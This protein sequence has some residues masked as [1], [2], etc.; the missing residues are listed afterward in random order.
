MA[1]ELRLWEFGADD[2]KIDSWLTAASLAHKI[3]KK[4]EE[5]FHWKF[6]GSP[7]GRAIL[8]CAFDG[9]NVA[10]CVSMGKGEMTYGHEIFPY[11]LVYDTFVHPAYQGKG[12][13]KKL[14]VLLEEECRNQGSKLS[15]IFPNNN[16]IRGWKHSGYTQVQLTEYKIRIIH[17]VKVM[18]YYRDLRKSFAC[19]PANLEDV[20]DNIPMNLSH[21][22]IDGVFTPQWSAEYI[23]WRFLTFPVGHYWIFN[24][25]DVFAIFRTGY[26]G[27]LKQAE[28]LHI[29]VSKGAILKKQW[30]QVVRRLIR[31]VNPDII[32]VAASK[33]YPIYSFLRGYIKVPDRSHFTYKLLTN[34]FVPEAFRMSKCGIDAHT[35]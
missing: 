18:R 14:I 7:Y 32:G 33:Y 20:K 11:T 2:D 30:R 6:E 9:D 16:A 28:L 5:W 27:K 1:L 29:A 31:E 10:G 13:F 25:K 34:D 35:Y 22:F 15:Y 26:R 12:I 23:K 3:P 24:E 21:V 17:P 19:E 4:T 8:A